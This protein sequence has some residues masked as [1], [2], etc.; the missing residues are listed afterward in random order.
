MSSWPLVKYVDAPAT[1]ATVRYD[2]NDQVPNPATGP[3]KKVTD[4]DPGV[5]T[6]EGDPDA[7]GQS[8]GFRSPSITHTI[9]ATKAQAMAALSAVSRE[10]LRRTNWL[11]F[12]PSAAQQPVWFKTYRTSYEPLSLDQVYVRVEGG[13]TV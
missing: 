6:L 1:T 12:Q 4:F 11:L 8:W 5:P 2:F 13:G 3:A 7:V 10:Q 9:K